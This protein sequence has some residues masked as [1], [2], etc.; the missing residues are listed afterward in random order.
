[1]SKFEIQDTVAIVTDIT[2]P[3]QVDKLIEA[4]VDELL[5]SIMR[6]VDCCKWT[7]F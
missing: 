2:V 5:W 7:V 3:E 4:T 6:A 1:M